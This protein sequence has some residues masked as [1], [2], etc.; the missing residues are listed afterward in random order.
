MGY[1]IYAD[2]W[3]IHDD[4]LEELRIFE[5]SLE[6]E[7]N[8]TGSFSFSIY[9][10]HSYYSFVEKIK[11]IITVYQDN[12][13]L[14]RGRVLDIDSGFYNEKL[15]LCEGE[16]AFLV[17]SIQ[18]P[19]DFTGSVTEYFTLLINNHNS[20]VEE[21]KQFKVGNADHKRHEIFVHVHS[22]AFRES[23]EDHLHENW[24][25]RSA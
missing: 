11:T 7:V 5:P 2:D 6:L 19:Y 23:G 24:R 9:P 15:V 8:K 25:D 13:L 20:Q 14:F 1:R 18:R 17:D 21:A 3:L 16:L 10:D 4:S 12:T 22:C